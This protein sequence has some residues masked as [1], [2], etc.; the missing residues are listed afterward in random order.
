MPYYLSMFRGVEREDG[1]K[2]IF[3]ELL[4]GEKVA[5]KSFIKMFGWEL[6]FRD[7]LFYLGITLEDQIICY[8]VGHNVLEKIK[9]KYLSLHDLYCQYNREIS[10]DN[11]PHDFHG[12]A[13]LLGIEGAITYRPIPVILSCIY[14]SKNVRT[15]YQIITGT[16]V[17]DGSYVSKYS[18]IKFNLSA[19][20]P[21]N[22]KRY[23]ING[24]AITIDAETGE[25]I[26]KEPIRYAERRCILHEA[27]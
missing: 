4:C 23:F 7:W 26:K 8:G 16:Y 27:N 1:T 6:D 20:P 25:I 3:A 13:K 18:D 19:P 17:S 9:F 11:V 21:Q 5:E 22:T 14:A 10:P 15:L 24:H 2:P 12:I